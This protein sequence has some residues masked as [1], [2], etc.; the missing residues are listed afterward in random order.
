MQTHAHATIRN[1]EVCENRLHQSQHVESATAHV[2]QEEHDANA[3]A[4]LRAESTADHICGCKQTQAHA[5]TTTQ[6]RK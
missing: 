2:S 4:E 1:P 6:L 5:N 3:A